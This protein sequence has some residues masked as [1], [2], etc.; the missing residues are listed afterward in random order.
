MLL[1]IVSF[2]S[3]IVGILTNKLIAV[4]LGVVGIGVWGQA[5]TLL[6]FVNTPL[7]NG[8]RNATVRSIVA[9]SEDN[10]HEKINY[11]IAASRTLALLGGGLI[12]AIMIVLAVPLSQQVF[13]DPALFMLI[14]I[15]A[16]SIPF[17]A[18][19]QLWL[20]VLQGFRQTLYWSITSVVA[21]LLGLLSLVVLIPQFGVEGAL[22]QQVLVA[23]AGAALAYFVYRKRR[24]RVKSETHQPLV[25]FN[26]HVTRQTFT[27]GGVGAFASFALTGT[28]LITRSMLVN[29]LGV[30]TAGIY[31]VVSGIS[32]QY[33]TVVLYSMTTYWYPHFAAQKGNHAIVNEVNQMTR[34][35]L[36]IIIPIFVMLLALRDFII[37][38]IYS[39]DFMLSST[40][41]PL[42]IAGDY[43]KVIYWTGS[44]SAL[45]TGRFRTYLT[46]SISWD[47]IYL[48]TFPLLLSVGGL[49]GAVVA[50]PITQVVALIFILLY[51]RRNI[52]LH[53]TSENRR[54]MFTGGVI[55][56]AVGVLSYILSPVTCAVVGGVLLMGWG[57]ISTT[58]QERMMLL[59]AKATLRSL[60]Q[61]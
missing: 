37:P 52:G 55:L 41:L 42:Q 29:A 46:I 11:W 28:L 33:L 8:L 51:E 24:F 16:L 43:F 21:L 35:A 54:M 47:V 19:Q 61:A 31:Q 36:F 30:D 15:V 22:F 57:I 6:S 48:V 3:I 59:N 14:I 50:Y 7:L 18:M 17:T 56:A 40:L 45:P 10:Q 4:Q 38:L 5:L 49:L 27:F 1:W 9:Y 44:Y 2:V 13:G 25:A 39:N 20:A 53:F 60:L 32:H 12:A 58:S 34:I 23:S 26:W